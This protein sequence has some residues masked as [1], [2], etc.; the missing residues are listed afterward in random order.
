M[1]DIVQNAIIKHMKTGNTIAVST[2]DSYFH[3]K[4]DW[5]IIERCEIVLAPE[6]FDDM[7][8]NDFD[9]EFE[10]HAFILNKKKVIRGKIVAVIGDQRFRTIE[11]DGKIIS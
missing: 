2:E 4:R 3:F 11:I 8:M 1:I 5:L 10:V 7:F 9:L 6:E